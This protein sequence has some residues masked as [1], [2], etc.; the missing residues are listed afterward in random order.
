MT[1]LEA[2][3]NSLSKNSKC[4]KHTTTRPYCLSSI[5]NKT[6]PSYTNNF[7]FRAQKKKNLKILTNR[8]AQKKTLS[9]K[10]MEH[11]KKKRMNPKK[12]CNNKENEKTKKARVRKEKAKSLVNT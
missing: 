7:L 4:I 6:N 3:R 5:Y 1:E 2:K 11:Q 8:I 10:P 9:M 12:K